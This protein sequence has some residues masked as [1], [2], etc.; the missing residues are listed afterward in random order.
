[1]NTKRKFNILALVLLM[2][3][4]A[5]LTLLTGCG[6]DEVTD[7]Y[8]TSAGTPRLTYVQGQDL[9]L[10]NGVLTVVIDG[11]ESSIPMDSSDV[12]VTGYNKD[13]LGKQTITITYQGKSANLDVT[14]IPRIVAES[15]EAS[16]FVGDDFNNSKGRLR[17]AKDDGTTFTVNM[18][19]PAVTLKSFDSSKAGEVTCTIA[20]KNSEG[21]E[22]EGTFNVN[23]YAVKEVVFTKPT[24][25]AY[26]D[27]ET[28]DL[29]GAYFTVK[30][31]GSNL[32]KY[33]KITED[34]VD[35]HDF[36]KVT[37][38]HRDEPLAQTLIFNYGGQ[39]FEFPITI[40][41]SSLSIVRDRAEEL[42]AISW[43]N[44]DNIEI[45]DELGAAALDAIT[46]YYKL[47]NS[48]KKLLDEETLNAFVRP[49]A[50]YVNKLYFAE[51]ETYENSFWFD[52]EGNIIFSAETPEQLK[53]DADRI[54]DA[55][56]EFNIYATILR[57]MQEDF[58]NTK[59]SDTVTVGSYISVLPAD[60]NT[61]IVDISDHLIQLNTVLSSVPENWTKDDLSTYANDITRAVVRITSG[62]YS[63][64]NYFQAY[65]VLSSWRV[66]DDYFEILYSYYLYVYEEGED[67]IYEKMWEKV[68]LPGVLN[69]WY[70]SIY[71][72]NLA[73]YT[74][75]Y[76]GDE[77]YLYDTSPFMYYYFD[78]IEKADSIKAMEGTLYKDLYDL[79]DGDALFQNSIR[80]ANAG[81]LYHAGE[82][83]DTEAY[84]NTWNAYLALL[85]LAFNSENVF[86]TKNAS[87]F[88]AVFD[89]ITDLSP[90]ELHAFISSMH[91][92]YDT[93]RGNVL[94]FDYTENGA[95][96]NF[97]LLIAN[98][99]LNL[100]PDSAD[101]LFQKLLIAM[102]NYSLVG[103]K[104]T[105]L[106][107]FKTVMA[108][109]TQELGTIP[110]EDRESFNSH[111][112]TCYDKYVDI[113][114]TVVATEK[115]ELGVWQA[116]LDSLKSWIL[117]FER[118]NK[119]VTDS[120]VE[121]DDKSA[122]YPLLFAIYE[123]LEEI[124]AD[125]RTNGTDEAIYA[126]YTETLTLSDESFTYDKAFYSVRGV[127]INTMIFSQL[128]ET[129]KEGNETVYMAWDVY[130]PSAVGDFLADAVD[131]L[132]AG[133]DGTVADG[134]TVY[135]IMAAFR[136]APLEARDLFYGIGSSTL[137][138]SAIE[139]YF[140]S[141][142]EEDVVDL[143]I[144]VLEA[145]MAYVMYERGD[146]DA[147]DLESFKTEMSEAME[148]LKSVT[149]TEN[150][151]QYVKTIYEYYLEKYTALTAEA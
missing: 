111:L 76:Y 36:S 52:A 85:D 10:G 110:D 40:K 134:D 92:L 9:D 78:V 107:D 5:G 28:L 147:E 143:G 61:F 54:N 24:K 11:A 67:Y 20:Y 79:F 68:P 96:S 33:V 6:G 34:M 65:D 31:D 16:Y 30:A 23:V 80:K 135:A 122:A 133:F 112:S 130:A 113:Y 1:M 14:V 25:S 26:L 149:S 140:K 4:V 71:Q 43:D 97:V 49:A 3:I 74:M 37:A 19:D 98:Y 59:L 44:P 70:F 39:V 99:Y 100:L 46:E 22:Y 132:L 58:K 47:T 117:T 7:I 102:E 141:V 13:T 41:Y 29:S 90:A 72:A 125:I 8:V 51:L 121:T 148:L 35:G 57:K 139:I 106:E 62:G 64:I 150:Y 66:K 83:L 95:I 93:A 53:T 87:Y 128:T 32:S 48:E 18:N 127:F 124:Y 136:T 27:Y 137:Y 115:A 119:Y 86:D 114:N 142:L 151:E 50:L 84:K 105:A 63:G 138:Y 17:V 91:F 120:T 89:A 123:K 129:D 116:K 108:E 131:V 75:A 88:E 146:Y 109:L 101:P 82:A 81:Y 45:T 55:D 21:T 38:T 103:I 104:E 69:D 118:V 145:E 77:A 56:E 15:Y 126:L 42:K 94:V 73:A 144:A 60:F 2:L 12:T